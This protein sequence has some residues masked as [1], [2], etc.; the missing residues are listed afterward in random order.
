MVNLCLSLIRLGE[1]SLAVASDEFDDEVIQLPEDETQEYQGS[2]SR[3]AVLSKKKRIP[4]E[5]DAREYFAFNIV[6][7]SKESPGKVF[8]CV[9]YCNNF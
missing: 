3:L 4:L 7:C 9:S 6:K 8:V 1:I 2:F 5:T